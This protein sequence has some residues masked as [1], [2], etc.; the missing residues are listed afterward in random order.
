MILYN[1]SWHPFLTDSMGLFLWN[2]LTFE[3][4]QSGKKNSL[5][6][7]I[8]DKKIEKLFDEF[9]EKYDIEG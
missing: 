6:N 7:N 3:D 1:K 8:S 4:Q 5:T 9:V 2:E